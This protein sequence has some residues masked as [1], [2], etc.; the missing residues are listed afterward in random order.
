MT[1]APEYDFLDLPHP[2][3]R[4]LISR[5][6]RG[7]HGYDIDSAVIRALKAGAS[8]ALSPSSNLSHALMLIP[9]NWWW[10]IGHLQAEIIPTGPADG[11][12]WSNAARHYPN[13]KPVRYSSPAHYDRA[14]LPR[15]VCAAMV[16]AAYDI[17]DG[18]AVQASTFSKE[19]EE[20]IKARQERI[21]QWRSVGGVV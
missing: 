10:H 18:Y 4:R 5:L 12:P 15:A 21:D 11:L 13:G 14:Q 20:V 1:E 3:V 17:P 9:E 6:A 2:E 16:R 19:S 7:G 8:G